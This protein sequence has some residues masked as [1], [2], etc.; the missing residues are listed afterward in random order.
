MDALIII[1][2]LN[3][4]SSGRGEGEDTSLSTSVQVGSTDWSKEAE[5]R[6]RE[7][8]AR[9]ADELWATE[10]DLFD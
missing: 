7:Q 4:M 2:R 5:K 10:F 6:R 9:T 1:N 3:R 8:L